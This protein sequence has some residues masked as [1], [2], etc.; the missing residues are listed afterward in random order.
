MEVP[1]KQSVV[2]GKGWV[3]KDGKRVKKQF[4]G[5]YTA[6]RKAP[7]ELTK[8]IF[9]KEAFHLP[10]ESLEHR[11]HEVIGREARST[12]IQSAEEFNHHSAAFLPVFQRQCHAGNADD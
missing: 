4:Y 2:Q 3:L 8:K 10:R 12:V 1:V 9:L 6:A 7:R 11:R 5:G